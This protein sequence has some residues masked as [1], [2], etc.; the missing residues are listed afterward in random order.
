MKWALKIAAKIV[1]SRLPIPYAWWQSINLFRHGRMDQA[2]YALK[3]FRLHTIRAYH[4]GL[5]HGATVL[6]LGP[7][8]SIAS[9]II[10]TAHGASQIWLVDVGE[11]A[12]RDVHF[13]KML[14]LDLGLQGLPVPDL[15]QAGSFEDVLR[16]CNA[17]YLTGGLRSLRII[18]DD[19][20]D[21]IWSHS[22]LEHVREKELMGV[23][24]ELWRI[25][26]PFGFASHNI[27]YQDHLDHSLNNLRFSKKLWE[28]SFFANS[29]FY[30]N[31]MP[32]I[33]LHASFRRIGYQV[34]NENFGKWPFMPI[35]RRLMHKD[36]HVYAD[37]E[38][39][40]KTSSILLTKPQ[41]SEL[42]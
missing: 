37:S 28:S 24:S 39:I 14:A 1:L 16:A 36:F 9:A 23:L 5:P 32:A 18:A 20:I 25:L 6:E 35:H 15:A 12:R 34:I 33:E 10:A 21:F 22:V 13:Y 3:I 7:G 17:R 42:I 31:R 2:E 19:S 8:D 38:L 41:L 30:T 27:D 29:R 26:K 40:N 11:F 4:H